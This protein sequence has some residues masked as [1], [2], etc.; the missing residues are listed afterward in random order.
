MAKYCMNCGTKIDDNAKF[1]F[2]C[3][4]DNRQQMRPAA[5]ANVNNRQIRPAEQG[6]YNRRQNGQIVG[7]Y[8]SPN[9]VLGPDGYY[10]WYYEM[11]MISN[12]TLLI[13][14]MKALLLTVGITCALV[15]IIGL[16]TGGGLD[17]IKGMLV[18][19]AIITPIF[20]II[21]AIAYLIVAAMN[22]GKYM[23]LF[24]MNEEGVIHN[25]MPS[26][27]KKAQA[28]G[29]LGMLVGSATGN[30]T[31]VG[32]GL[33]TA[34]KYS[35]SSSFRNVTSVKVNRSR[36]TIYVNEVLTKNQVYAQNEDFP[37]VEKFIFDHCPG[38]KKSY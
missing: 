16:A 18:C 10:R 37:F 27:F 28:I 13:T 34:S 7:E 5:Q 22:G 33:V 36:N 3:G 1:C 12:P 38:A 11:N 26:Q 4:A 8:V 9:I 31:M 17:S 25:Q 15:L 2:N 6:N 30:L 19:F 24:E 32:Q 29:W 21:G 14:V 20:L 35:T 23:V